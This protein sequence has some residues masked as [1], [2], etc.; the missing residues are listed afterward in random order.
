MPYSSGSL[1]QFS[2]TP[3]LACSKLSSSGS[4][5][6]SRVVFISFIL[7][8]IPSTLSALAPSSDLPPLVSLL[9]T[10]RPGWSVGLKAIFM[11]NQVLDSANG[12]LVLPYEHSRETFLVSGP[13][14]V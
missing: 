14:R 11:P 9:M 5:S 13:I 2:S 1:A 8:R 6:P 7:A 12:Q 3:A 10:T 4:I